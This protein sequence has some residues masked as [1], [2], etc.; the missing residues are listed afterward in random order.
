MLIIKQLSFSCYSN[1]PLT[2][3]HKVK[4]E[5]KIYSVLAI[6][7]FYPYSSKKITKSTIYLLIYLLAIISKISSHYKYLSSTIIK[8]TLKYIIYLLISMY[9]TNNDNA[10]YNNIKLVLLLPYSL[11]IYTITSTVKIVKFK[12]YYF[13]YLIPNYLERILELLTISNILLYFLLTFTKYETIIKIIINLLLKLYIFRN[14]IFQEYIFNLLISSQYLERIFQNINNIHISI[15]VKSSLL[16][17]LHILDYKNFLI[18]QLNNFTEDKI[19]SSFTLWN[20]NLNNK[21]FDLLKL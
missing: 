10:Q 16:T 7:F 14:V 3:L 12:L 18:Q 5:A 2:F 19:Y 21:D 9:F 4:N 6:L 15:K 13:I 1:S 11:K 8:F 20:R 17:K